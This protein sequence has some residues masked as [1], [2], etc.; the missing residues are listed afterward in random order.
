[1]TIKEFLNLYVYC[2][3]VMYDTQYLNINNVGLTADLHITDEYDGCEPV[4]P[5]T[6]ELLDEHTSCVIFTREWTDD[7]IAV[8]F[9]KT[10]SHYDVFDDW[11]DNE[12]EVK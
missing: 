10:Q 1:M 9:P 8:I 4:H 11:C 3:D 5:W 2:T 7:V 12:L 6:G